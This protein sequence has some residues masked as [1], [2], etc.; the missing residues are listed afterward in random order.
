MIGTT[1][2]AEGPFG[3]T[4]GHAR[5]LARIALV[6]PVGV[7]MILAGWVL[8]A[9]ANDWDVVESARASAVTLLLVLAATLAA[10]LLV[11]VERQ[12]RRRGFVVFWF[13][14]SCFFNF[15]WQVPL[16][17]FR[18]VI[19]SAERTHENLRRFI[20]WWGYGFADSHYGEVTRW[21]MSEELW[22][23]LAIAMSVCGLALLHRGREVRGFFFLGLAG[24]LEAYNASLYMV[25]DVMTGLENVASGSALSWVL[26]WGFNPLWAG[27]ALLASVYAFRV[28]LE[29]AEATASPRPAGR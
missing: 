23:L 4:R 5:T 11:P 15:T 18:S 20:A 8:A 21:M 28:V 24:A 10:P 26:Y 25:Y 7:P 17:L 2:R 29:R 9:R 3:L 22:W 1:D 6:I 19:T 14:V 13:C 16:I 27:S 12:A